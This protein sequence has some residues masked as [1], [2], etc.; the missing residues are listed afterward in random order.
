MVYK[1]RTIVSGKHMKLRLTPKEM[2]QFLQILATLDLVL[3][4]MSDQPRPFESI[5]FLHT[6]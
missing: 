2:V 6:R 4:S 3:A 5:M 1:M